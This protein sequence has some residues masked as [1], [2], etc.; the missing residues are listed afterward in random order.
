ML[1]VLDSPRLLVL[2]S[3]LSHITAGHSR[4]PYFI[5]RLLTLRH[6]PLLGMVINEIAGYLLTAVDNATQRRVM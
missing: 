6:P 5:K 2:N 1:T 4:T 3:T